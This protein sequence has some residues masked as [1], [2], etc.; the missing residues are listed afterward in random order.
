MLR[1]PPSRLFLSLSLKS[2]SLTPSFLP[3]VRRL[4]ALLS[5]REF[6]SRASQHPR[7][8]S[9][10][11]AFHPFFALDV[12]LTILWS[13]WYRFAPPLVA[14]SRGANSPTQNDQANSPLGP[15]ERFVPST[16]VLDRI[17]FAIAVFSEHGLGT[18]DSIESP[19]DRS[20]RYPARTSSVRAGARVERRQRTDTC[21][22]SQRAVSCG[23]D[24]R[25]SPML[26]DPEDVGL[27]TERVSFGVVHRV[28]RIAVS[29]TSARRG[30]ATHIHRT[31]ARTGQVRSDCQTRG[32]R[33]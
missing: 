13:Q 30:R 21:E 23:R 29:K 10:C 8:S 32:A 7:S 4:L 1:V 14:S 15:S 26:N 2:P 22:E 27:K 31:S 12:P 16:F 25:D 24:L 3:A 17:I 28:Y 33:T 18:G 20:L 6:S 9:A 19:R 5:K 11:T